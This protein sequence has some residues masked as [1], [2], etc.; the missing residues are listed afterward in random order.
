MSREGWG[1][2]IL[3][4][5]RVRKSDFTPGKPDLM[6]LKW[7]DFNRASGTWVVSLIRKSQNCL[8]C[9]S[10]LQ[11]LHFP[12]SLPCEDERARRGIALISHGF[13]HHIGFLRRSSW[14]CCLV[15]SDVANADST[16]LPEPSLTNQH[17]KII[18][19]YMAAED[20]MLDARFR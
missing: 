6:D 15:S 17:S 10:K 3:S 5:I 1:G 19:A 9:I 13:S 11:H 14:L 8:Q 18:R 2:A 4:S 20:F 16:P 12:H 7:P